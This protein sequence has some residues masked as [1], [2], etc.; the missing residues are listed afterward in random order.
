MDSEEYSTDEGLKKRKMIRDIEGAFEKSKKTQRSPRKG[1]SGDTDKIDQILN[2]VKNMTL[3]QKEIKSEIQQIRSEQVQFLEELNKLKRENEKLKK[4]YS[5]VRKENVEIKK[6]IVELK[7]NVERV[8]KMNRKNNIVLK[9]LATDTSEPENLKTI[10]NRFISEHLGVEATT[11]TVRK[12]GTKT[13]KIELVDEGI[14][15]EII[16]NK[17]KLRNLKTEKIFIDDDLTRRDRE[18]IGQLRTRAKEERDKGNNVK[19]GY[20]KLTI[21]GK[22]WRWN[23]DKE[24]LEIM[25]TKN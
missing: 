12:I 21:N 1:Q 23:R 20:N 22:E 10:M 6:E 16:R 5:N 19:I 13:Y 9:G 17:S 8:E 15:A 24:E 14:K 25:A 3:E 18:K 2:I 7:N 11:K 4:E